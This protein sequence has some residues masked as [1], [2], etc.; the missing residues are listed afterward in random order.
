MKPVNDLQMEAAIRADTPG[1]FTGLDRPIPLE[2][3]DIRDVG[4]VFTMDL[5]DEEGQAATLE[6]SSAEWEMVRAAVIGCRAPQAYVV[7]ILELTDDG[8]VEVIG[9]DTFSMSRPTINR[10]RP[11]ALVTLLDGH[12]NSYM[13][14]LNDL[15]RMLSQPNYDD[16]RRII[17]A[18]ANKMEGRGTLTEVL[19][20]EQQLPVVAATKHTED[21]GA[22]AVAADH[23]DD[24][25]PKEAEVLR[26]A[27]RVEAMLQSILAE[28][29]VNA[30][31]RTLRPLERDVFGAG[32]DRMVALLSLHQVNGPDYVDGYYI[33]QDHHMR[34]EI[35]ERHS[36]GWRSTAYGERSGT[37]RR[38]HW[39]GVPRNDVAM[40]T[41]SLLP[42]QR[43][44]VPT[45]RHD[46]VVVPF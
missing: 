32:S 18:L 7:A 17:E 16:H 27:D 6:F 24:E 31:L 42:V 30:D 13:D 5:E 21:A 38:D 43:I 37:P 9:A 36:G 39:R 33:V 11:M 10:D 3:V 19:P 28:L 45:S 14:G 35:W 2:R 12:G 22:E 23:I 1:D 46:D 15:R 29:R 40:A 44:E 25:H 26:R 34:R 41:D 20:S 4:G 8:D